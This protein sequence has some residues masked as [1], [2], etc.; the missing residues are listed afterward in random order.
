MA[1]S[2]KTRNASLFPNDQ[3]PQSIIFLPK[4]PDGECPAALGGEGWPHAVALGRATRDDAGSPPG[5]TPLLK[6]ALGYTSRGN[7]RCFTPL[8]RSVRWFAPLP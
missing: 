6:R 1:P 4:Q 8:R 3:R 7:V 2:R 5:Y